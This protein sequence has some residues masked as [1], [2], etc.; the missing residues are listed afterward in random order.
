ML[1]SY[2]TLGAG[3]MPVDPLLSGNELSSLGP[4]S[5]PWEEG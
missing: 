4:S 2:V 3:D 1:P 5:L